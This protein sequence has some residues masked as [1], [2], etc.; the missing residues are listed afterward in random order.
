[1]KK[2]DKPDLNE[3]MPKDYSSSIIPPCKIQPKNNRTSFDIIHFF[4]WALLPIPIAFLYA[5]FLGKWIGSTQ[6][7][8]VFLAP[9]MEE[10]FKISGI[11]L[12]TIQHYQKISSRFQI[13]WATI[14]ASLS[15]AVIE[16]MLYAYIRLENASSEEF[17][18]IMTFRWIFLTLIHILCSVIA[19]FGIMV[20]W[21][22]LTSKCSVKYGLIILFFFIAVIIHCL[23]NFFILHL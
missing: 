18:L 13:L 15:F 4:F 6:F 14:I 1:M 5:I 9:L 2:K 7:H 12:Y 22:N 3:C 17:V 10:F 23:Y 11:L 21:K 19:S 20:L 16:N 8:A